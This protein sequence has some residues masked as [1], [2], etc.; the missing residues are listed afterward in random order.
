MVHMNCPRGWCFFA[1]AVVIQLGFV[2]ATP[3]SNQQDVLT[4]L[5]SSSSALVSHGWSSSSASAACTPWYGVTCDGSDNIVQLYVYSAEKTPYFAVAR[6]VQP[7]RPAISLTMY[8]TSFSLK[9][10]EWN[11]HT[12]LSSE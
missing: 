12:K 3:P 4:A 7:S 5:A 6:L 9:K 1:L 2:V 8:L 11:C 10:L